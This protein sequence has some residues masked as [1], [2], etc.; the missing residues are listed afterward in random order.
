MAGVDI[1]LAVDGPRYFLTIERQ[2]KKQ[3]AICF[4]LGELVVV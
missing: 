3:F 1:N 4:S 2:T